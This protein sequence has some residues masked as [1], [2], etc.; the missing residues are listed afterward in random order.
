MA[1]IASEAPPS[2]VD[3][4]A[5]S[6]ESQLI[7]APKTKKKSQETQPGIVYLSRIPTFM[8]PRR[9]QQI[10]GQHGEIGRT[11]MQPEGIPTFRYQII[12]NIRETDWY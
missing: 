1:T 4:P 9:I 8:K 12:N 2:Q 6:H 7:T 3:T 5:S 10:F 11:F